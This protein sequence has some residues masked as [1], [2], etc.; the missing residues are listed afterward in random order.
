MATIRIIDDDVEIA[1]NLAEEL[2]G[3]GFTVSTANETEG[4]AEALAASA[5]DLS[6]VM[7]ANSG[8]EAVHRACQMARAITGRQKIVKIAGAYDGWFDELTLGGPGSPE[9]ESLRP[10]GDGNFDFVLLRSRWRRR[11]PEPT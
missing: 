6:K 3:R 11:A 1:D 8:S 7:F 2:K 10:D 5:G 9:A 4:A